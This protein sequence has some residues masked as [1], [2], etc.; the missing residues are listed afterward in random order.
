M[1][2]ENSD[3][4]AEIVVQWGR[5]RPDLDASPL[6]VIGRMARL[7][8]LLDLRLRPPFAEAGL[9]NGDFDVIAALRRRGQP[10]TLSPGQL[11]NALLVT[12]GAITKRLD[13]LQARR[14]I[15]R[16]VSDRDARA[17]LVH[18]TPEGVSLVDQLIET[19]FA[20]ERDLLAGLS[21]QERRQLGALLGRLA[22]S[23]EDHS[24][25]SSALVT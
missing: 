21:G 7:T 16:H 22:L 23:L 20:N 10:Y 25:T 11:S 1:S 9:G 6:L 8:E 24:V 4:V 3:T 5:E 18:L 17:R 14:L 15:D 13:R 12:T 19:H 2:T